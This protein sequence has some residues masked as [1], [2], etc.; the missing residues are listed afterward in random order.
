MT[1]APNP[2]N[3]ATRPETR[4]TTVNFGEAI[5]GVQTPLSWGVWNYGMEHACRR[6]FV[7]M[8]VFARREGPPPPSADERMSGVFLGRAAGNIEVL[9]RIGDGMPGSSGDVIEEKLLG[10]VPSE[11]TPTPRDY[12]LTYPRVL[13]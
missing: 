12:Y 1:E 11:P 13:G 3:M 4:W 2:V 9:R 5:Q 10:Q 7:A 8:G 6:A